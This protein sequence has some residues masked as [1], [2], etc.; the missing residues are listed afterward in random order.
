M[1]DWSAQ[2]DSGGGPSAALTS[3]MSMIQ[4]QK[5]KD[6]ILQPMLQILNESV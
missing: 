4:A 5:S 1:E 6:Q 3:L 2:P